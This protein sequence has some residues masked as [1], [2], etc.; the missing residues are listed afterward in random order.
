VREA[1]VQDI[2]RSRLLGWVN[3][4]APAELRELVDEMDAAGALGEVE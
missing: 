1:L 2:G 3:R 4:H